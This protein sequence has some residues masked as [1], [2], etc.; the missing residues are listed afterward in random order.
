MH[1]WTPPK[2]IPVPPLPVRKLAIGGL[3]LAAL[4]AVGLALLIPPLQEGKR[5]GAA[6]VA[7]EQAAAV[8]AEEAR[9]RADQKL[10]VAAAPAGV[11]PA[12]AL[13]QA[14]TADARARVARRTLQGPVIGTQ[15]D[16]AGRYAVRYPNSR[17]YKCIATT[18]ANLRGEGEDRFDTGYAF[19]GTVYFGK[20]RL[21]WCKENPQPGEKT[22]GHGVA[23][24]AMSPVCAGVLA[25]L[26]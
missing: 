18:A 14:I 21:A 9:L 3:A 22:G 12:T 1:V 15:C 25:K 11:D 8:A 10:H 2:D 23:H 7:R 13:E 19:V 24:V 26:L 20:R 5:A 6:R 16:P 4:V 17:V